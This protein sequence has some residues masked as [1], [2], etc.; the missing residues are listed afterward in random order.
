MQTRSS[1]ST[2]LRAVALT[3]GT[4]ALLLMGAVLVYQL[5]HGYPAS[6]PPARTGPPA[7]TTAAPGAASPFTEAAVVAAYRQLQ[8]EQEEAYRR[9]DA[10]ALR[11]L[12]TADCTCLQEAERAIGYLRARGLYLAG[13]PARVH[14]AD[15]LLLDPETAT[16]TLRVRVSFGA[17]RYVDAGGAVRY[18]EPDVGVQVYE[19]NMAWDG[20]RWRQARVDRVAAGVS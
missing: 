11:E 18:Q 1:P 4:I 2:F 9:A 12:Y 7:P 6:G 5:I 15:V 10:A 14:D 17:S 20:A 8:R 13:P 19:V 16:A 3:L